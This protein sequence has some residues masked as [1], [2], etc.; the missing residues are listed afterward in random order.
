MKN[1]FGRLALL[2]VLVASATTVSAE[3]MSYSEGTW[4]VAARAGIAP[5][6]FSRKANLTAT[7]H[8][9]GVA[10]PAGN[11]DIDK[12][13]FNIFRTTISKQFNKF[14]S[15]P[16]TAGADV[17]YFV[18]DNV[19]LFLNFDYTHACS[20]RITFVERLGNKPDNVEWKLRDINS[21]AGYMGARNYF[22]PMQC[23]LPFVGAKLGVKGSGTCGRDGN[24]T[25]KLNPD[26]AFSYSTA[27]NCVA[28]SGGLQLGFD[29]MFADCYAL[30]FMSEIIGTSGRHFKSGRQDHR[31]KTDANGNNN[32]RF[33]T[34]ITRNPRAVLSFPLT[35]GVRIRM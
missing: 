32:Y 20:K 33:F 30:T 17:G 27:R 13:P 2:S 14:Y 15:L 3:N 34:E 25:I 7:T 1:L 9:P 12:S 10:I 23:I 19:E 26:D 16:F 31:T 22:C 35:L 24:I 6:T 29:W 28:F 4:A 11:A 8:N 5:S 21:Y 18:M